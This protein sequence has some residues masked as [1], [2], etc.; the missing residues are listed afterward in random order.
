VTVEFESFGDLFASLGRYILEVLVIVVVFVGLTRATN[1]FVIRSLRSRAALH[2]ALRVEAPDDQRTETAIRV[3]TA[4]VRAFFAVIATIAILSEIGIHTTALFAS[5]SI[6]AIA[7]GFGAQYLVKDY[8]SGV[9][10]LL[11]NQYRIGDHIDIVGVSGSVEDITLRATV[12]RDSSGTV[13]HV[14]NGEVRVASNH[15][16]QFVKLILDLRVAYSEDA[17]HVMGVINRVGQSMAD[18]PDWSADILVAPYAMRIQDFADSAMVIRV[19]G[20]TTPA[21]RSAILGELRLRLK[22]AFDAEGIEIPYPQLVVHSST[23][24]RTDGVPLTLE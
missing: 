15:S 13:H 12:L 10:I 4:T 18:D 21:R 9:L 1:F 17:Q 2:R 22:S 11:E 5:V 23:Y 6:V 24:Q 16:R 7:L 20:K 19:G 3:V 14:P 8:I